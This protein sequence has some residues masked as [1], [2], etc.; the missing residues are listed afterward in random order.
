MTFEQEQILEHAR[1]ARIK[2]RDLRH[3]HDAT[4]GR[5]TIVRLFA[6]TVAADNARIRR[7]FRRLNPALR[8]PPS[9]PYA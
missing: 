4:R 1:A 9:T 6:E 8:R 3:D 2:A 5:M 7:R